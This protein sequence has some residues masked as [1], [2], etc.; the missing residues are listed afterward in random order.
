[1]KV[2]IGNRIYDSADVAI[3]V[4][5]TT[6]DEIK[7]ASGL[8]GRKS[9]AIGSFPNG[10]D[11]NEA[12]IFLNEGWE[13]ITFKFQVDAAGLLSSLKLPEPPRIAVK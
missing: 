5:F 12:M 7:A 6:D 3:A 4:M 8:D 10:T 11:P 9:R 13:N 1:M 2:K